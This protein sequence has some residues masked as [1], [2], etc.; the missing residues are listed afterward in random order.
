MAGTKVVAGLALASLP[1]FP[2]FASNQQSDV[3]LAVYLL[4][5]SAL[6]EWD[7]L[8]L[9]GFSA[10]LGAWTKNEGAMMLAFLALALL[11]RT[12]DWRRPA[13]F[14]LGALPLLALL[15]FYKL[16]I[17]PP[18][19]LAALSTGETL[20][21]H[22]T[23]LRRWGEL[24]LMVARRIVYF[25]DFGIWLAAECAVLWSLRKRRPGPVGTALF[26]SALAFLAVYAL[27]PH[28]LQWI[29]R[30]SADRLVM[31]LWPAAVLATLT[32]RAPARTT[33][34]T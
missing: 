29:F 12:R 15:A 2:V 7:A 23:D 3:P 25:Q 32:A 28:P 13:R 14:V 11:W 10:G 20:L 27:Q 19:D 26:L 4:L 34:R 33:A 9:A 6:V 16:R 30:T 17:A 8:P 18:T 1:C 24:L 5:A 31:Q 22:A 21:G